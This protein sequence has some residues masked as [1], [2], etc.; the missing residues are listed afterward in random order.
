MQRWRAFQI[1]SK[2]AHAC[3]PKFTFRRVFAIEFWLSPRM[4]KSSP[5]HSPPTTRTRD[6]AMPFLKLQQTMTHLTYSGLFSFCFKELL[7]RLP[8]AS[9]D[10]IKEHLQRAYSTDETRLA[11]WCLLN[12]HVLRGKFSKLLENEAES[13]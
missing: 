7:H 9:Y 2:S 1:G 12:L 6:L 5:D 11:E 10:R 3:V 4:R 13:A 8:P